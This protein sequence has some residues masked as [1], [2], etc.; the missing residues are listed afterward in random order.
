MELETDDVTIHQLLYQC[1][2]NQEFEYENNIFRFT[3]G[4]LITVFLLY[5]LEVSW[6]SRFIQEEYNNSVLLTISI[7]IINILFI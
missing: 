6:E 4:I 7:A 1:N 5:G 3:A 2:Y